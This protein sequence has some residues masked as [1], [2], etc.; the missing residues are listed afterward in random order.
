M[1]FLLSGKGIIRVSRDIKAPS[2]WMF[3]V[4]NNSRFDLWQSFLP[5]YVSF[6][7][8]SVFLLLFPVCMCIYLR[9]CMCTLS[10]AAN[11]DVGL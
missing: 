3:F 4:F 10:L 7:P 9:V 11:V 2:A 1:P 8:F 6:T 5:F